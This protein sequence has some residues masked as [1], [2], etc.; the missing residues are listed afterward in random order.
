M[1]E[2][3]EITSE[4][5]TAIRSKILRPGQDIRSCIYPH[6]NEQSTFHLSAY[7][8]G[9]QASIVS[10]YKESNP[11]FTAENQYRFRGMATLD[12]Y[13][14]MGFASALL[15]FA[16]TKLKELN[17]DLTWCNARINALVLY[18][19]L[20]MEICS[21]EFDIPGIGAHLILKLEL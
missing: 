14:N 11:E 13:R 3:R 8:N 1:V 15:G 16:F 21:E 7:V 19:K 20:G 9:K 17:V 12:E 6:D 5:T 4:E 10:F 18:K 2:I